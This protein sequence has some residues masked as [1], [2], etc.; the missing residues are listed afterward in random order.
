MRDEEAERRAMFERRLADEISSLRDDF[1]GRQKQLLQQVETTMA[2]LR[3]QSDPARPFPNAWEKQ[4]IERAAGAAAGLNWLRGGAAPGWP[5]AGVGVDARALAA[6][7]GGHVNSFAPPGHVT[8]LP[9]SPTPN[10]A[11]PPAGRFSTSVSGVGDVAMPVGAALPMPNAVDSTLDRALN[12]VGVAQAGGHSSIAAGQQSAALAEAA[13][14][15]DEA[16]KQVAEG[17]ADVL[18]RLGQLEQAVSVHSERL[19]VPGGAS[20]TEARQ[21]GAP[22][23]MPSGSSLLEELGA[24]QDPQDYDALLEDFLRQGADLRGS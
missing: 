12:A 4:N 13:R 20:S 11:P 5:A 10:M 2:R 21:P 18:A 7:V 24:E 8:S 19:D 1:A 14:L 6:G 9:Q 17:N 3:V 23:G 15:R 16:H 22:S